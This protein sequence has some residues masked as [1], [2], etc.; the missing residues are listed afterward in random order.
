DE[1]Y[2]DNNVGIGTTNPAFELDIVDASTAAYARIQSTANNAAMVIERAPSGDMAS[3]IY[4][5]G[6][7]NSFYTG[8]LS[9]NSYKISTTNPV[10]NGLE[11]EIDGDVN[12]SDNLLLGTGNKIGIGVS[13]PT[14]TMEIMGGDIT[15][16]KLYHT[17]SG[18]GANNGLLLGIREYKNNAYLW[19]YEDGPI[20][21]GTNNNARM[22]INSDGDVGIGT[23]TPDAKLDVSG[24]AKLG[25]SGVVFSEIREFTGTTGTGNAIEVSYPSGYTYT[26][27]RVLSLEVK[28]ANAMWCSM[29]QHLG[30]SPSEYKVSCT[31]KSTAI[32]IYYPDDATMHNKPFR[33][34]LMK[35]E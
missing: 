5:T 22:I 17:T 16:Q 1:I 3:T 24:S 27:T 9:S 29:G 11:V 23:T 4:K 20:Y 32:R 12:L 33:M 30:S 14:N 26:N 8:L 6:G 10:L 13:N 2:Y 15:Y 18:T 34:I 28:Y 19:N 21:I 35:A 31:L 25:P 7:A